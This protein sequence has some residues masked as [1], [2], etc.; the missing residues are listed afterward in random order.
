MLEVLDALEL[1]CVDIAGWSLG[2][3]IAMHLAARAPER[4]QRLILLDPPLTTPSD[5]AAASLARGWKRLERTYP[6]R[7]TA[8]AAWRESPSLPA[9]WDAA[10]E[11]FVD[12]DLLDLPGGIVGH[13]MSLETLRAERSAQAPPLSS[14]IPNIRAQ[15]LILR[16][17]DALSVEGDQL[18]S[19][20]DA[21]RAV[22]LFS[23][24]TVQDIPGANHYTITLGTPMSTITAIR[25]FLIST[26]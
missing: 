14:V 17:T 22:R 18:L 9:R 1:P 26:E 23:N 8:L 2:S 13:R 3:L 11:A 6:D 20:E 10:V 19:A 5:V 24:A 7:A 16:A 21:Q 25:A 15:T 12:A 4:V